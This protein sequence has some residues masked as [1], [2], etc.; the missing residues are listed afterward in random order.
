[1]KRKASN[2]VRYARRD[3]HFKE[4]FVHMLSGPKA[5]VLVPDVQNTFKVV[6]GGSRGVHGVRSNP[7]PRPVFKY[8]IKK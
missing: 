4:A 3:G 1:M 5:R 2:H 8:L 7:P 6:S